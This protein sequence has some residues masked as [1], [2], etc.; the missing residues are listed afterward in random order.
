M[1][2]ASLIVAA[3]LM[4]SLPFSY[5]V[6]RLMRDR[7][8]REMGSGNVGATNTLRAVGTLPALGVLLLDMGKGAIPVFTALHLGA[9][10]WAV[11]GSALAAVVGHVF[12]VYLGFRG[13]K[14]VATALGALVILAPLP[15][16]ASVAGQLALIGWLR[17][18]SV[19]SMAGI[20]LIAIL[21]PL[22]AVL[23]ESGVVPVW[24]EGAA[25]LVALLVV[26]K[27]R[28]NIRRLREGREGRLGDP[29]EA[30][31]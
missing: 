6:V 25:V 29:R 19:G 24:T 10:T 22:F 30:A 9:P 1:I 11:A 8:I 4:G 14:G 21:I 18:V 15:T 20:I 26:V 3:Y 23:G 12:P 2:W 27:H 13:G 5:L 7:D 31:R 17:Y 28:D 16:L